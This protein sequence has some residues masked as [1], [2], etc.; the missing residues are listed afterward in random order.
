MSKKTCALIVGIAGGLAT[1]ASALVAFY[2]DNALAAKIDGA[3]A[4]FITAVAQICNLFVEG[5]SVI[6]KNNK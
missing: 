2:C 6:K 3:I 5:E 1:V 4:L